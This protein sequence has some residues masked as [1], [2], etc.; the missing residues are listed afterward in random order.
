MCKRDY[1]LELTER[2]AATQRTKAS[3]SLEQ[4]RDRSIGLIAVLNVLLSS[5]TAA[6][7]GSLPIGGGQINSEVHANR[8]D[9]KAMLEWRAGVFE[10]AVTLL[11]GQKSV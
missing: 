10:N 3:T 6:L 1:K 9:S 4:L 2:N 11:Y 5:H 7:R 8:F